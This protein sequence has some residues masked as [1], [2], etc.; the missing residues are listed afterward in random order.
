[1]RGLPIRPRCRVVVDNDWA[2]DP[3]GLV[4]LAH[5]LLSPRNRVDAVTSSFL[6]P[7]FASPRSTSADGAVAA[8]ALLDVIG[9]DV[10]VHAGADGPYV[11]GR[12]PSAAAVRIVEAA[13]ADDDLPLYVV[14]GGPLTNVAEALEADPAIA[15]RIMLVWIGGTL[16]DGVGEYNRDTDPAAAERVFAH[17][18]L[19]ITQFPLETYRRCALSVAELQHRIGRCG[20]V[21]EFLW[22]QFVELPLPDF[23]DLGEVWPLGDS[24]PL[25]VTALDDASSAWTIGTTLGGGRLRVFTEIDVRLLV[26]DLLAKLSL[27]AGAGP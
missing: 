12:A 3:D 13:A 6:H 25:L 21:G 27:H 15:E 7:M 11:V 17:P 10:P 20:E 14:C 19:P 22:R 4:A 1:M 8:R 2:G 9:V 26:G 18:G 23:V 24:P 16:E 5:H